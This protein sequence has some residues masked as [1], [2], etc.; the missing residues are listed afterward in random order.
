MAHMA[1]FAESDFDSIHSSQAF[2]GDHQ[3]MY[4]P[5]LRSKKPSRFASTQS[6]ILPDIPNTSQIVGDGAGELPRMRRQ[7][8]ENQIV[9]ALT[10]MQK[11]LDQAKNTIKEL[12]QERDEYRSECK[13][14]RQLLVQ[15]RQPEPQKS[16]KSKPVAPVDNELFDLT[17]YSDAD[18]DFTQQL[19]ALNLSKAKSNMKAVPVRE[20]P[21]QQKDHTPAASR[22]IPT[23]R[24]QQR[25]QANVQQ[26]EE[27]DQKRSPLR[28][29]SENQYRQRSQPSP[30]KA[31]KK[32]V[33]EEDYQRDT[34][35][36]TNTAQSIARPPTRNLTHLSNVPD[37]QPFT[38]LRNQLEAERQ[39]SRQYST[40]R[41]D[42][43]SERQEP[44]RSTRAATAPP[45]DHETIP[46]ME[47][48]TA[49]S[50]TSR[51][52]RRASD[53]VDAD[54]NMTSAYIIPD[55][56]VAKAQPQAVMEAAPV[57]NQQQPGQLS[58]ESKRFLHSVDPDHIVSCT[59]CRRL[60][61]LPE[62]L[63]VRRETVGWDWCMILGN[64]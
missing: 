37:N 31:S 7:D 34:R 43:I 27:G 55:I 21:S 5:P 33:I 8:P 51:R 59:H 32:V 28:E 1:P 64:K 58:E 53:T 16:N 52:R 11:Q 49:A 61:R 2:V 36:H 40:V 39:T 26:D 60:L 56:T 45:L 3:V 44:A 62:K 25:Q 12:I 48:F 46:I 63:Q 20:Q 10:R 35:Q 30:Q 14:L 23:P 6:Y 24:L 57:E 50:N 22:R 4:T 19:A 18:D 41:E 9:N 42:K 13:A 29:I 47:D 54:D 17:Q 38:A 15:T